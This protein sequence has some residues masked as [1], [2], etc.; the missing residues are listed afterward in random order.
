MSDS[1]LRLRAYS[2]GRYNILIVEPASGGL[3]AV[4]AETG[5]DLERSKPVEERWMYE[6]AIGRHE[7]VEVRP[8]RSVPASGLREYVEWELRD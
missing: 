1:T 4:Y 6:N 2:P 3:R 8:P 5:Y 7:F